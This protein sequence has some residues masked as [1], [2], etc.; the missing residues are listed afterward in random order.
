MARVA[1]QGAVSNHPFQ[2]T[3]SS[4][5]G[6]EFRTATAFSSFLIHKQPAPKYHTKGVHAH[7]LTAREHERWFSGKSPRV[8]T[9][10]STTSENQRKRDLQPWPPRSLPALRARNPER[11][12]RAPGSKKC[13]KQSQT[14]LRSVETVYVETPETVLRLFRTLFGLRGRTAPG[15][16]V[17]TLSG[18]RARRARETPVR[19]GRGCK[20]RRQ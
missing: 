16:S 5:P 6:N 3:I 20:A 12:S 9:Q 15:D 11:V 17:E 2:I 18:F 8:K 13:P 10:M 1:L 14:S 19:G 7:P 4:L